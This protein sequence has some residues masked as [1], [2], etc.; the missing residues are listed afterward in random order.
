MQTFL[1]HLGYDNM[2]AMQE[3]YLSHSEENS[4]LLANTG[5]G[6][7]LAFLLKIY[8]LLEQSSP[9][10]TVLI[11]SPTRELARQIYE[12]IQKMRLPYSSIVCFGGHSFK[13][14]KLQFEQ[15][16]RI[17]VGTPGRILDHY[18]RGTEGLNPFTH[19]VIDEYD[20]TLELGFLNELS[21]IYAYAGNLKSIQLISATAI[22]ALPDFIQN[23]NFK[24]FPYITEDKP[25]I[26][27]LDVQAEENDKLKALSLLLTQFS[28][29]PTLVFCTH[30]EA[31]DRLAQH[32]SEYG[33]ETAVFHGG[34]EQQDRQ[35]SL[36]KF[37]S[38][39]VDCLLCSDLASRGIDISEIKNVVHYQYP[40]TKEDFTHRN[41]RTARMQKSGRVFLIHSQNEPLPDYAHEL[42]IMNYK[43]P[44]N[45]TDYQDN[46]WITLFL[47][48]GRKHKIR[49]T[50]IVGFLTQELKL[51]FEDLGLIEIHDN[52]SYIA[53]N[54]NYYS[55]NKAIFGDSFK[56]KKNKFKIRLSR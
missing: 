34:L 33:K 8:Q 32:L 27:Y 12:V 28:E 52:F 26:Q 38:G 15:Q 18:D 39:S 19:L 56:L 22:D 31:C 46:T 37:K 6:K 9:K 14:E 53:L 51:S 35:L 7:T 41:G 49:K 36:F 47:N 54:K 17:V 44:E 5:S 29:E 13:N 21:Q 23:K 30:R 24:T 48:I 2:T 50:D 45:Y 1:N 43:L 16:P 25:E 20:K 11:V 3:D 4:I 10:D 42:E 55:K 40:Q